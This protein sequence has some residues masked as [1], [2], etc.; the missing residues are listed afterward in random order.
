MS[1][2][3]KELIFQNEVIA[4]RNAPR[5]TSFICPVATGKIDVRRWQPPVVSKMEAPTAPAN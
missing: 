4:E 1:A 3:T 5:R 2:P